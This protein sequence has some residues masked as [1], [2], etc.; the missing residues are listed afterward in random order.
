MPLA[1]PHEYRQMIDAARAGRF[2]YP[3]VNVTSSETLNAALRGFAEARSDG[4]IQMTTS[5]AAYLAGPGT[6]MAAG[7]LGVAKLAHVL[8]ARSPVLIG[9]HT[10]HCTPAHVDTFLRPLLVVS[11]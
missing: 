3:A 9:L 4:I 5:A 8:A 2:A 6:D 11:R 7:A 1:T 10:D